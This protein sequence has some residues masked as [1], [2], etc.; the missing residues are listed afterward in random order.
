VDDIADDVVNESADDVVGGAK[1]T[2]RRTPK[3][4]IS[5]WTRVMLIKEGHGGT[6]QKT[7]RWT[8]RAGI[9][10]ECLRWQ[11]EVL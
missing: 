4:K 8:G 9:S 1:V 10:V 6:R 3:V 11:R 2:C 7:S 5:R